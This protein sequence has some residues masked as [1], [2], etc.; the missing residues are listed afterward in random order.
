MFVAAHR[1]AKQQQRLD[2][3]MGSI[4]AN[5]VA[6]PYRIVATHEIGHTLGLVADELGGDDGMHNPAPLAERQIMNYPINNRDILWE[7][8]WS[9]RPHNYHYL[10]FVLP[11]QD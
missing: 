2:Y 7:P 3:F 10:E 8:N 1:W 9:W 4:E 5:V 11:K 6:R